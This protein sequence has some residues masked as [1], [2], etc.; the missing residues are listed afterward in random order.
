MRIITKPRCSATLCPSDIRVCAYRRHLECC[1]VTIW[2]MTMPA[3]SVDL[4]I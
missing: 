2:F 3:P 4:L 1:P